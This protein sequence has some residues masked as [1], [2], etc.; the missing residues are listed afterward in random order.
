[1]GHE[2]P[3]LRGAEVILAKRFNQWFGSRAT[4]KMASDDRGNPFTKKNLGDVVDQF[5]FENP[6]IRKDR[7]SLATVVRRYR[8]LKAADT[9]RKGRKR[10]VRELGK[11]LTAVGERIKERRREAKEKKK[12]EK[13]DRQPSFL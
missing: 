13:R 12:Q 4:F 1:M 10:A 2:K 11:R 5:L 3:D 6:A 8:A 9:R 7:D